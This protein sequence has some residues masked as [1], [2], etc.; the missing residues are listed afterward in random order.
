MVCLIITIHKRIEISTRSLFLCVITLFLFTLPSSVQSNNHSYPLFEVDVTIDEVFFDFRFRQ[1]VNTTLIAYYIEGNIYFPIG[2]IFGH[3]LVF[4]EFDSSTNIVSGYISNDRNSFLLD[5]KNNQ[6]RFRDKRGSLTADD[7]YIDVFDTYMLAEK[8]EEIFGFQ[9]D[10]DFSLLTLRLITDE[11][12]PIQVR[13]DRF[14]ARNRMQDFLGQRLF[15]DPLIERNPQVFNG[16]FLDYTLNYSTQ[17][18]DTQSATLNLQAGAEILFGD[19]QASLTLSGNQQSGYSSNWGS[20]RWRYYLP[21]QSTILPSQY[22][23]GNIQNRGIVFN[24]RLQGATVTNEPLYQSRIFDEFNFTDTAQPDSEVE[25][26]IN[27]RLFDYF[28]IDESGFYSVRLPITFGINDI[29]IV[30]YSPDGQI[31]EIN[32][33]LNVPFFFVPNQRFYYT[34]Y[35][36]RSQTSGFETNRY[37]VGLFD[38][39]YGLSRSMTVRAKA[40]TIQGPD[41]HEAALQSE[42]NNRFNRVITSLQYSPNRYESLA[43]TY[44]SESNSFL[45]LSAS[46]YRTNYQRLNNTIEY[47]LAATGF[48]GLSK[49]GIPMFLRAGYELSEYTS[50]SSTTYSGSV[51]ARLSRISLNAGFRSNERTSG[52]FTS[53]VNNYNA[54]LSYSTPRQGIWGPLTGIFL[55]SQIIYVND[56]NRP[57]QFNVS[58]SRR[59]YQG[60]L[61]ASYTHFFATNRGGIFLSVNFEIPT[62]RFNTSVRTSG[63]NYVVNQNIR[64][65]LGYFHQERM[66]LFDNRNQVGRSAVIFNSFIDADGDGVYSEGEQR[67][68]SGAL[69]MQGSG[70]RA[71]VVKDQMVITGLRPYDR[72]NVE[73]NEAMITDPTLVSLKSKFSLV[74]DPNQFKYI[75]VPFSRS[76]IVDGSVTRRFQE[77]LQPVSGLNVRLMNLTDSTITTARTFFDGSFFE[78]GVIPGRYVAYPDST[79]LQILGVRAEPA[80]YPFEIVASEFGDFVDIAFELYPLVPVEPSPDVAPEPA[81]PVV[82]PPVAVADPE[83][84]APPVTGLE[85]SQLYRVQIAMMPTLARAMIARERVERLLNHPAEITLSNRLNMYRV[86]TRDIDDLQTATQMLAIVSR[87]TEHRDAYMLNSV[88]Y[89]LSDVTYAVQIGAFRNSAAADRH[90][91]QARS[92]FGLDVHSF[93]HEISGWFVVQTREFTNWREA[94]LLRDRI[95]ST[96]SYTD[97]F[98]SAKPPEFQIFSSYS[99]QVGAY[100]REEFARTQAQAFSRRTGM[101]FVVEYNPAARLYAVR[102]VDLNDLS[103][104]ETILR[105][106]LEDYGFEEGIILSLERA[107]GMN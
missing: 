70:A 22:T 32:R 64:G 100:A 26:F 28:F 60:Q 90:A 29:R 101:R 65:S 9:F 4:S 55:R 16:G 18:F 44:Q 2:E 49:I 94:I 102:V 42:V 43:L 7:F 93:Y 19:F 45:N 85:P 46:N 67:L 59:L 15:H 63:N 84:V 73:V 74:T 97:A 31:V 13:F 91:E 40:E 21:T 48:I 99:V 6:Y 78:M 61:Q 71:Q 86:L 30:K 33:R 34:A 27:D 51:T 83:P 54:S 1:F 81:P 62:N 56:L 5:F 20:A 66:L 88:N 69:R 25:V 52:V 82:A 17:N 72:Y 105:R 8:W 87:E 106:L 24:Q 77:S 35:L 37:T 41:R 107:S 38:A 92:R 68:R 80:I 23:L 53:V 103:Q 104:A 76:G 14:N 58:V 10:V 39:G 75:E 3:L 89:L 36:G 12:L 98:T 95:R 47:R 50:F 96:T 79:Q 57:D 11:R